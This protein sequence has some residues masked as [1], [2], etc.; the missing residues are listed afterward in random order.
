[1]DK[2][3]ALERRLLIE[4]IKKFYIDDY[5][6]DYRIKYL[7]KHG[8]KHKD[9]YGEVKAVPDDVLEQVIRELTQ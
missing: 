6:K 5:T 4:R 3:E 9:S 2:V 1:M 7:V 8:I